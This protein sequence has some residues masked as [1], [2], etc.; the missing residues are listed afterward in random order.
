MIYLR[1][2][3]EK[4][5][6]SYYKWVNN[7]DIQNKT[8]RYKSVSRQSHETWF[9][10]IQND[11]SVYIF[12]IVTTDNDKLI[13][14]CRITTD[15]DKISGELQI[16]IGESDSHNNGYGTAAVKELTK[17]GFDILNLNYIYLY[18]YKDNHPAIRVYKKSGYTVKSHSKH[19]RVKMIIKSQNSTRYNTI[20][21]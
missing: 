14:T 16:K 2:I 10:N 20:S 15:T 5:V 9:E 6:D 7:P 1:K 4:D 8:S 21:A 13:G 12:S 18:V 17:Y 3:I 11:S 19:N